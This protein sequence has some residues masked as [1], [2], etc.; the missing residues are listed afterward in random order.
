MS[1]VKM[2]DVDRA[3]KRDGEVFW[4][5]EVRKSLVGITHYIGIT[6]DGLL[7]IGRNVILRGMV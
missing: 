7:Q 1:L 2:R 6:S 5:A 4:I 3:V